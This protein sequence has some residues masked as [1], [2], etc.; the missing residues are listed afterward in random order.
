VSIINILNNKYS[1]N[2]LFIINQRYSKTTFFSGNTVHNICTDRNNNYAH[3]HL[4]S[5]C[6]YCFRIQY[7]LCMSGILK[8]WGHYTRNHLAYSTLVLVI[9][10][11]RIAIH[12]VMPAPEVL[13]IKKLTRHYD[14]TVQAPAVIF[15]LKCAEGRP[16][17]I[18][19]GGIHVPRA[20]GVNA[21]K[22]TDHN[23]EDDCSHGTLRPYPWSSI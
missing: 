9:P 21:R 10:V 18:S 12:V 2:R 19:F 17:N 20:G 13:C 15:P 5:R 8:Y 22:H 6:N 14:R 16:E 11:G 3:R 4:N 7:S 1:K 23:T